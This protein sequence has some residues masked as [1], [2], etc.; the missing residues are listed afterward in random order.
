MFM[1]GL[2]CHFTDLLT[3]EKNI[4]IAL[5]IVVITIAIYWL[6]KNTTNQKFNLMTK[7]NDVTSSTANIPVPATNLQP[8]VAAQTTNEFVVISNYQTLSGLTQI[9]SLH[10]VNGFLHYKNW[11]SNSNLVGFQ[12]TSVNGKSVTFVAD[13]MWALT[14][15][16]DDHV[17]QLDLHSP[18]LDI[19]EVRQVGLE[20]EGAWG[21]DPTGFL[22]WCNKVGNNW[23]DAPLYSAGNGFPP[24][25]EPHIGFSVRRTTDNEKPWLVVLNIQEDKLF[26][27]P[28]RN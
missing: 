3:Y 13:M 4:F 6:V 9:K 2:D 14:D 1:N 25:P 11:Y 23:I 12:L 24:A 22:T 21:L 5:I 18:P 28:V 15:R 7:T 17:H 19:D 10:E 20:L 27:P 26:S 16:S 8:Q